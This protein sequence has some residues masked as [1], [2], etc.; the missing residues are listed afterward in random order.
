MPSQFFTLR[1]EF[2][3]RHASVPYFSGPGG[4]TPPGG[5]QGAPGSQ[6]TDLM[7]NVTWR[8]DLVQD[9]P[10]FTLALLVKL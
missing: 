9:E 5:N 2:T 8:P 4:I 7:G 1:A 10:R 6:V 3:L